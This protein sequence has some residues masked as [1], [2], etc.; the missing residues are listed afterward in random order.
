MPSSGL[1]TGFRRLTLPHF[2]ESR[3]PHVP[4]RRWHVF[5][6]AA[7]VPDARSQDR[8]YSDLRTAHRRI[9]HSQRQPGGSGSQNLRGAPC[10]A[11][12]HSDN[13]LDRTSRRRI[14][15][16]GHAGRTPPADPQPIQQQRPRPA[17]DF[18]RRGGNRLSAFA[19][20]DRRRSFSAPPIRSLH[21]VSTNLPYF[22][23]AC[24]S[25]S[26]GKATVW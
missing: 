18:T 10:L 13:S 4:Q 5:R 22:R 24:L 6:H 20:P 25:S 2:R 3:M 16:T 15:R 7:A 21:F 12:R 9:A 11:H 17:H 26:C 19:A 23:K 8:S 14:A 1:T